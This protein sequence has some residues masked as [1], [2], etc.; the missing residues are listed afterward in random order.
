AEGPRAGPEDDRR[1]R[2]D[3]RRAAEE[4]RPGITR[5]LRRAPTELA[6]PGSCRRVSPLRPRR[7]VHWPW[8]RRLRG[9]ARMPLPAPPAGRNRRQLWTFHRTM[10]SLPPGPRQRGYQL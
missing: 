10:R 3:D 8:E 5:A 6:R 9:G 4:E 1:P 2:E 7:Q